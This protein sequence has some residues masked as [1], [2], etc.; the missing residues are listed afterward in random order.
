MRAAGIFVFCL[1]SSILSTVTSLKCQK[2]VALGSECEKLDTTVVECKEDEEFCSTLVANT[3]ITNIAVS[4]IVKDC[5]KREDCYDGL[6]IT[7]IVDDRFEIGRANCC[8]TDVCNAEPLH[9][10]NYD[11]FQPNGLQCPGCYA[12]DEDSCEANQS[13]ICVGDEDQCLILS[14]STEAFG[15]YTEM[16]TYQGCTTKNSCSFPLG[17]TEIGGGQ[18]RFNVTI[19]ECRNASSSEPDHQ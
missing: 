16:S 8:Q 3:T 11:E 7:T 15:N 1:F 6:F 13:V 9:L 5:S 12:L 18:I 2:C 10:E 4:L 14:S 17:L 19:L